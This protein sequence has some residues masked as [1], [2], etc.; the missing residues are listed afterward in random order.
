M[1]A[2]LIKIFTNNIEPSTAQKVMQE[3]RE[4]LEGHIDLLER[5]NIIFSSIDSKM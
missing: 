2:I 4:C 3:A 1:N 5:F